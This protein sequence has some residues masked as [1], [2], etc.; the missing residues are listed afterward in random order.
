MKKM[1][2]KLASFY[3]FSHSSCLF[4]SHGLSQVKAELSMFIEENFADIF[5]MFDS[6]EDD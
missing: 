6:F 5:Q 2:R 1:I 4:E 3:S